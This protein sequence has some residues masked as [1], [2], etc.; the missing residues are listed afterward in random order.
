MKR[1]D[2]CWRITLRPSGPEFPSIPRSLFPTAVGA[3]GYCTGK[4]RHRS[5]PIPTPIL[6]GGARRRLVIASKDGRRVL[7]VRQR[8][9]GFW[10]CP[11]GREM[12]D[13][14]SSGICYG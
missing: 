4:A 3:I 5:R 9:D 12:A 11:D 6:K 14:S 8:R 7:L 2:L 1:R 13:P 10:T